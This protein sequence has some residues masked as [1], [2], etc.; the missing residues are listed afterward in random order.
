MSLSSVKVPAGKPISDA[1]T[2]LGRKHNELSGF[3]TLEHLILEGED[4]L[5]SGT[6]GGLAHHLMAIRSALARALWKAEVYVGVSIIDELVF[7]AAKNNPGNIVQEVLSFL[8]TSRAG[9]PGFVL[10]PL[11]GFGIGTETPFQSGR[12]SQTYLHFR[13]M[14]MCLAAQTNDFDSTRRLVSSMASRLGVAGKIDASDLGHHTRAGN[15]DWMTSNPLMMVRVASHTGAYF[16]NQFIYTLKI[17]VSAAFA[18]ML[19]A[20]AADR[21]KKVGTF[22][23]TARVN[24]WETLD[25][26]H[27]LVG[28]ARK[29]KSDAVEL[30]RVP[31]NV[32]ALELARLS[33]LT[34]SLGA[35]TQRLSF[36]RNAQRR[37]TQ[38]L[39]LVEAG[40]LEHVNTASNDRVRRK[41][42]ARVV[43]ALN[44]Y[45]QSFS[46]RV[47]DDE[48]V[49]ALA[50]AFETLLTDA[51]ARGVAERVKR[52]LRIC[53]KGRRGID[54]YIDAVNSVMEAR[55]EI[56][57]NG[58][59]V[60]EAEIIKAQAAFALCFED[61]AGRLPNLGNNLD[62]PV[63][64]V[65]GDV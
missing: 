52:R 45:R 49:V 57:H 60:K 14:A 24:N 7:H 56:V 11:H 28:E 26:H 6:Y 43:T 18:A 50:V 1:E 8:T 13:S 21:G 25:I 62:R 46:A 36:V 37:L 33:D 16:E 9:N 4:I 12:D 39:K 61:V 59:T 40:H 38:A 23:T 15:M 3:D 48:A 53:L 63:G 17:R 47:T 35:E 20:L 27:Y 31:M 54:E 29:K 44:W 42:F 58:S 51:Y 30:R 34:L 10:Y 5:E 65:L 22:H 2:Y 41:V 32:A 64:R 55:G 19:Y